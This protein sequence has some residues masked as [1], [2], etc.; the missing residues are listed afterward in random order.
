MRR[1]LDPFAIVGYWEAAAHRPLRDRS[2]RME[3]L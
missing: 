3:H 1:R 2:S